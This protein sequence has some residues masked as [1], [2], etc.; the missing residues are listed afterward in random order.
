MMLPTVTAR[1]SRS[2][3]TNRRHAEVENALRDLNYSVGLNHLPSG[4]FGANASGCAVGALPVA[5][6]VRP[7]A[8]APECHSAPGLM[9]SH[10]PGDRGAARPGQP[11]TA[12]S[13]RSK[14]GDG[15]PQYLKATRPRCHGSI[16][17]HQAPF[18]GQLCGESVARAIL[19][20]CLAT[21]RPGVSSLATPVIGRPCDR[22][23]AAQHYACSVYTRDR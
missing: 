10:P 17:E 16:P 7:G 23:P 1:C 6:R 22:K 20:T 4:R 12:D 8:G 9:R 14:R 2:R 3:P 13:R 18:A 21:R 15:T 11:A 5:A 19:Q